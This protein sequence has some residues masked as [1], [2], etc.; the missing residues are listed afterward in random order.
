MVKTRVDIEDMSPEERIKWLQ[1]MEAE[2]KKKLRELAEQEARIKEDLKNLSEEESKRKKE[3]TEAEQLITASLDE[4]AFKEV[5]KQIED[6][7]RELRR[8]KEEQEKEKKEQEKEKKDKEE[9]EKKEKELEKRSI[10]QSLESRLGGASGRKGSDFKNPYAP[11]TEQRGELAEVYK[12]TDHNV[13]NNVMG[14][15]R[16]RD[17]GTISDEEMARL[18]GYKQW[19]NNF[20][21]KKLDSKL[22]VYNHVAKMKNAL[23]LEEENEA[24]EVYRNSR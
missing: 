5:T 21:E 18:D 16:R 9:S 1:G 12:I 6:R 3:L 14:L 2:R 23:G 11:A 15:L 4:I 20:D 22:D 13:Y 8:I 24:H 7:G 17:D 19:V 10:E